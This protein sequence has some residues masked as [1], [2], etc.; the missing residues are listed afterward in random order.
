[1][2]CGF[3]SSNLTL[4]PW[5]TM[6]CGWQ[7]HVLHTVRRLC[8][9]VYS[10]VICE[11]VL[12]ISTRRRESLTLWRRNEKSWSPCW[13]AA[14]RAGPESER[15]TGS[16][17]RDRGDRKYSFYQHQCLNDTEF[18]YSIAIWTVNIKGLKIHKSV[19]EKDEKSLWLKMNE[20]NVLFAVQ[21]CPMLHD[22]TM[23]RHNLKQVNSCSVL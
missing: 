19:C 8:E 16:E 11:Q 23:Q 10:C 22:D 12:L 9:C 14:Q 15:C 20:N 5:P 2:S 4:D 3:Y 18:Q 13:A 17:Q 7:E 1:M 6:M 21:T